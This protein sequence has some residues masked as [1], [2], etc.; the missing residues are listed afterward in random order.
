M[1]GRRRSTKRWVSRTTSSTSTRSSTA[2]G[3]GSA[4]L[5]TVTEQSP[6]S[7]S[8]VRRSGLTVPS[9]RC[10]T[11]PSTATTYSLRTSTVPGTTHWTMP[12][13][14]RRST[15]ARCSP[16]SRR[17]ATQPHTRTRLPTSP[18][19]SEPHIRSRIAVAP[20]VD[21]GGTGGLV[22]GGPFR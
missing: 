18:A 12:V 11:S 21:G 4:A 5:S 10:R 16:C 6:I 15:K 9:G 13:W 22:N 8:P 3:G 1:R 17:L 20:V 14:S 2:K 19:P 7:T